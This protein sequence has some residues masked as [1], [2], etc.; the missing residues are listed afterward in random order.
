MKYRRSL[1]PCPWCGSHPT[2]IKDRLWQEHNYNGQTVTHGYVGCYEYYYQCSNF[3]CL[4]VAP[5]GKIDTIYHTEEEAEKMAKEAW[6]TRA[7]TE[8]E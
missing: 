8:K 3:D 2:L 7:D 4:A 1:K 5:H 6:Q